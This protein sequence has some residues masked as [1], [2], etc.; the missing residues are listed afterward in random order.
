MVVGVALTLGG[1]VLVY[2]LPHK[3]AD[4]VFGV[5]AILGVGT[6]ITLVTSLS[7]G[8]D[9]VSHGWQNNS[10]GYLF[11]HIQVNYADS[12]VFRSET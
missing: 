8:S 1:C 12:S 4:A 2:L 6:A 10:F 5:A 7:M 9:L 11:S 3:L